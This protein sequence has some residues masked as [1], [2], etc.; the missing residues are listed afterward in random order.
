MMRATRSQ[1]SRESF[2]CAECDLAMERMQGVP[3]LRSLVG[4]AVHRCGQCG[5]I[6]LVQNDDARDWSVRWLHHI[7]PENGHAITCL[8]LV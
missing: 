3:I 7:S 2:V 1:G 5:H 4:H 8:P 6:L